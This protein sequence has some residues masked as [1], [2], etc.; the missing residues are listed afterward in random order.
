[1]SFKDALAKARGSRPEP[2]LQAVALGDDIFHVEIRRLDGMDWSAITASCPP[3]GARDVGLGFNSNK[4]AFIACK[5]HGRLLDGDG[6]AVDMASVKDD[7]G[8]VVEDPWADL[9]KAISGTESD[10]ITATWWHMNV[11]DPNTRVV[12][13]KKAWAAGGKTSSS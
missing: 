3:S 9:F 4:A 13:L 7:N 11:N 8:N 2:K 6:N 10:A 12:A 1:M 5:E